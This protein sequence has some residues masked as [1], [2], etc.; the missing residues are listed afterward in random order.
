MENS[1]VFFDIIIAFVYNIEDA[2]ITT[3]PIRDNRA[4]DRFIKAAKDNKVPLD[5]QLKL[6]N[7]KEKP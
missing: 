2:P 6:I 1:E 7:D 4:L 3:I 5:S